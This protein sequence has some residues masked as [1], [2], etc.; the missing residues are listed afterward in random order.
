MSW[1]GDPVQDGDRDGLA[2]RFVEEYERVYGP[3]SAWDGFPI[4]LHTA[5]V[6]G[7]GITPKPPTPSAGD[8]LAPSVP[9]PSAQRE[10]RLGDD[11]I[12]AAVHDGPALAPGAF[13]EGPAIVDDVDTTLL[14]PPGAAGRRRPA[15]LRVH[16]RR[17]RS[18]GRAHRRRRRSATWRADPAAQRSHDREHQHNL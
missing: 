5:R 14:V 15:Q 9:E 6:V 18:R 3:G 12:Q 4:E 17:R 1:P 8:D 7:S 10:V 2:A 13:I 16:H 11:T